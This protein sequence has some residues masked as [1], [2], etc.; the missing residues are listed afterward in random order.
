MDGIAL[1][2]DLQRQDCLAGSAPSWC[3]WWQVWKSFPCNL[4]FVWRICEA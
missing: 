2:G 1:L 4:T 3:R